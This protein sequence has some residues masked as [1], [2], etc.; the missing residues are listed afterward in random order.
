MSRS[1]WAGETLRAPGGG[2]LRDEAEI[3][4]TAGIDA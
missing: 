2:I 4:M 3:A 1:D